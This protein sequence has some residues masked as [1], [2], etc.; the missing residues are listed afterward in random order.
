MSYLDHK[1][2]YGI[3][4]HAE[5]CTKEECYHKTRHLHYVWG[6]KH[7]GGPWS[8]VQQKHK[9]PWGETEELVLCIKE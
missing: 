3:C 4:D 2:W 8:C 9:C 5:S 6:S 7:A 1:S